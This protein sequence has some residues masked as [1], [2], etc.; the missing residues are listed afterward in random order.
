[1]FKIYFIILAEEGG[2][3]KEGDV[4]GTN[5]VFCISLFFISVRFIS[6]GRQHSDS[7]WF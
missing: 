4:G 5:A 1:M 7:K 3:C 2:I 6:I